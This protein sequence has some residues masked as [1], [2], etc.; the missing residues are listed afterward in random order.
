M[1]QLAHQ[2]DVPVLNIRVSVVTA[3]AADFVR[4]Q[5][6]G[7]A[8][9]NASLAT[10]SPASDENFNNTGSLRGHVSHN[11]HKPSSGGTGRAG[12]HVRPN[13]LRIMSCNWPC[14]REPATESPAIP[15]PS[16]PLSGRGSRGVARLGYPNRAPGYAPVSAGRRA[17]CRPDSVSQISRALIRSPE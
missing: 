17:D 4:E 11:D 10:T 14:R 12:R 7:C 15:P 8:L 16:P 9:R 1:S 5:T 2:P 3:S 13:Q 6:S